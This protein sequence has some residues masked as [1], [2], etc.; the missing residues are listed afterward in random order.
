MSIEEC[1]IPTTTC[2]WPKKEGLFLISVKKRFLDDKE[3]ARVRPVIF[4]IDRD[5]GK[6]YW[7]EDAGTGCE[8][9]YNTSEVTAWMP[10]PKPYQKKGGN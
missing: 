1:W 9:Y 5:T 4:Y 8:Y 7:V 10:L 3:G 6:K 2:M